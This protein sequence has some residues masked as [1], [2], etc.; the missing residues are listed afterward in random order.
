MRCPKCQTSVPD[1]HFFCPNCHVSVYSYM[2]ESG[3]IGGGRLERAGRRLLDLLLLLVL[4]GGG[5]VLARAI[6]WKELWN[7]FN[8]SAEVS[9]PARPEQPPSGHATKRRAAS[10][11]TRPQGESADSSNQASGEGA[12]DPKSKV[13]G[14]SSK[15]EPQP[16]T[17]PTATPTPTKPGPQ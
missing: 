8:P 14:T 16:A 13:E 2:P 17:K 7:N 1:G 12:P 4:I 9:A 10:A 5:V 3:R 6:K 11:P 15:S